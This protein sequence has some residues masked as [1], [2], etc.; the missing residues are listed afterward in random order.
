VYTYIVSSELPEGIFNE[1]HTSVIHQQH[2]DV[3]LV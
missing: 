1:M 2:I 3:H